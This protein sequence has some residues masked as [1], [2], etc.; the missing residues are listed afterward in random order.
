MDSS[1]PMAEKLS[2]LSEALI[3]IYWTIAAQ[4]SKLLEKERNKQVKSCGYSGSLPR[5][6]IRDTAQGVGT[7]QKPDRPSWL[8]LPL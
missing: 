7:P 4:D 2:K 6:S 1:P 5:N 3:A 8:V